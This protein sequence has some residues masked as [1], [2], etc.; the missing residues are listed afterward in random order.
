VNGFG[1]L[2]NTVPTAF[3]SIYHL[4]SDPKLLESVREA[5]L[6]L[7]STTTTEAGS[8]IY[9]ID[10]REI[11]E[12]P[13]LVSIINES[14]RY[15]STGAA[16]RM[17]MEDFTLNTYILKKNSVIMVPNHEIHFH[18][19]TW[20]Q[21]VDRFDP[22]RFTRARSD[23]IE[24]KKPPVGAFRG[25]GS[26]VNMCP[27]KNFATLEILSVMVMMALRFD[28]TP[29]SGTWRYPGDD[30]SNMSPVITSPKQPVPVKIIPRA[31]F[32]GVTWTF[33]TLKR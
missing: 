19:E 5:A 23:D 24:I 9:T 18:K 17:V 10:I 29:V 26:G 7:L 14:L 2:I 31:G 1:I 20:G 3:W 33:R 12:M 16:P 28:I 22:L 32:E 13:L 27:G 21:A 30:G 4:F 25:F 8:K 6:P 11:R 15:H